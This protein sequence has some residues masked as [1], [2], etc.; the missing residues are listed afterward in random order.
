MHACM[1]FGAAPEAYGGSWARGPMGGV[2]ASTPWPQQWQI[3]PH[4]QPT[5]QPKQC[6]IWAVSAT[7]TTAQGNRW[8]LTHWGRPGIEPASSWMLVRCISAEPGQE[9]LPLFTGIWNWVGAWSG[10]FCLFFLFVCLFFH[11]PLSI[12][13]RKKNKR[14]PLCKYMPSEVRAGVRRWRVGRREVWRNLFFFFCQSSAPVLPSCSFLESLLVFKLSILDG[15]SYRP[16]PT[17]SK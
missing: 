16:H 11:H 5:P 10:F 2:A 6:R 7:Y 3:Q 13:G 9:L 8:S 12:S 1:L 14:K 17:S 15:P 4:L